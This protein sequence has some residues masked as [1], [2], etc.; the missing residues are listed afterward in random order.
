MSLFQKYKDAGLCVIP[1][2]K[3]QPTVKW[4]K[5]IDRLPDDVSGWGKHKEYALVC[6][7]V[8]GVIGLD[9]DTDDAELIAKIESIA[10]KSPVK[11]IG[12]KGFTAF[13]KYNG[14]R[15]QQW[16]GVVEIL[17]DKH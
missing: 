13:Y 8:S 9:I 2:H 1:L 3:G 16:G 6:G 17:S 14:E 4:G 10:G 15:T 5:Y 11:K 7:K 12:S